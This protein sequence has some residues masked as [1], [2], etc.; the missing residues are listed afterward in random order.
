M[1]AEQRNSADN[2]KM[3]IHSES[4]C[5]T[6][7]P[8]IS[9][10]LHTGILV[11]LSA[12]FLC[13]AMHAWALSPRKTTTHSVILQISHHKVIIFALVQAGFML[14]ICSGAIWSL[15][16]LIKANLASKFWPPLYSRHIMVGFRLIYHQIIWRH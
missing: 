15:W 2:F 10:L 9:S 7:L 12:W 14:C 4:N 1:H 13:N 11:N 3:E 5:L 16:E 6:S 8:Q